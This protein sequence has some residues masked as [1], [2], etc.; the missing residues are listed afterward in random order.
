MRA[1]IFLSA[2]ALTGCAKTTE[3]VDNVARQSAQASVIKALSLHGAPLPEG[4]LTPVAACI[5]AQSSVREIAEFA[6]D[7]VIGVDETT[8]ILAG[9]VLARPETQN[10]IAQAGFA[11]LAS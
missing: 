3:A 6:K 9:S 5:I 11:A 2:L 4:A 8:A 10:C 7:A 1:L